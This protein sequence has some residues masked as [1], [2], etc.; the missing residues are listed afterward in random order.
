MTKSSS[1]EGLRFFLA[2]WVFFAHLLPWH[3]YSTSTPVTSESGFY[4]L[5]QTLAEVTQPKS[6]LHPAVIGFLVLS[7]YVIGVGFDQEPLIRAKYKFVTSWLLRRGFRILPIYLLSIL[8]GALIYDSLEGASQQSLTGTQIL[9]FPCILAKSLSI[10]SF[11]PGGYPNCAFQGNAPLVTTAAEIALYIVFLISM[12]GV[13]NG[14]FRLFASVLPLF[15]LTGSLVVAFNSTQPSL[16]E[17]WT[18][19]SAVNYFLPWFAGMTLAFLEK[20]QNIS[21]V[22]KLQKNF[23]IAVLILFLTYFLRANHAIDFYIRQIMLVSWTLVFY[24]L[25][26]VFPKKVTSFKRELNF[27]GGISYAIYAL[28]AP[29]VIYLLSK[30]FNLKSIICIVFLICSL[31]Y[32]LYEK[33]IRSYGRIISR[34]IIE[35]N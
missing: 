19:A 26:R 16:L 7:G 33:P 2:M 18:H 29:L 17:W 4:G 9:N 27:L 11:F 31:T 6:S 14:F 1:L 25:L 5:F 21:Y 30:G 20:N 28:H 34:T 15:W 8:F 13:V 12:V 3:I 10:S 24:F 22:K 35:K 32:I 23:G